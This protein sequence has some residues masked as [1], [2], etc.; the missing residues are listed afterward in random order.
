MPPA[1]LHL[2]PRRS[3][4]WTASAA[5]SSGVA[6]AQACHPQQAQLNAAEQSMH[7]AVLR[8]V[9][10]PLGMKPS[11][12]A[13]GL[14]AARLARPL[15]PGTCQLANCPWRPGNH[16]PCRVLDPSQGRACWGPAP[17]LVLAWPVP[18]ASWGPGPCLAR[19][20]LVS[21]SLGLEDVEQG[22]CSA[23]V[24]GQ[25]LV[26]EQA[27][28]VQERSIQDS[29]RAPELVRVASQ[30]LD[31]PAVLASPGWAACQDAKLRD[32]QASFRPWASRPDVQGPLRHCTA[33]AE[34]VL[35]SGR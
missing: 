27:W 31:N 25:G 12:C 17:S 8:Q 14:E 26:Q 21:P 22:P 16:A 32:W 11:P 3:W 1:R 28:K 19:Q 34:A 2:R 18:T 24:R 35:V 5:A 20:G 15:V 29:R 9:G 23:L 33:A 30:A 7:A 6:K 4:S 13:P 10:L